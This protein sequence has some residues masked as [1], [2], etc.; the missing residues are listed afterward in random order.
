MA[1]IE[2]CLQELVEEEKQ[3]KAK[4]EKLEKKE[5]EKQAA[6]VVQQGHVQENDHSFADASDGD[7]DMEEG[8]LY[9]RWGDGGQD[10]EVDEEEE[11]TTETG[12]KR[13]VRTYSSVKLISS[14][15]TVHIHEKEYGWMQM[16]DGSRSIVQIGS[17]YDDDRDGDMMCQV[18]YHYSR[19]NLGE[20]ALAFDPKNKD[21]KNA[22]EGWVAKC[23]LVQD[24]HSTFAPIDGLV[25]KVLV[26]DT[27]YQPKLG[28]PRGR[29]KY[30]YRYI[31]DNHTDKMVPPVSLNR[32][33]NR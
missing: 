27:Q 15:G 5:R 7:S 25:E 32:N 9:H 8:A 30:F 28:T 31:Y 17:F 24:R 20:I 23:E 16:E 12:Q 21:S 22:Y 6:Q 33:F 11:H 19:K 29:D 4:Q 3:E 10:G 26:S 14:N 1:N 2:A 13:K 18:F